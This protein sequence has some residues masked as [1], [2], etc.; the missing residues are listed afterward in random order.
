MTEL[1][2][3]LAIR[4]NRPVGS[5]VVTLQ[6]GMC[7]L[8]GGSFDPAYTLTI[9]SLPSQLKPEMNRRNTAVLQGHLRQ[10]LRVTQGRGYIRYLALT[11]DCMGNGGDTMA[12]RLS[13]EG[14]GELRK[15]RVRNASWVV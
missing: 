14:V 9:T 10:A 15:A 1:S 4:Y 6:H 7:L 13:I 8:F 12:E 2:Q 3:H 11:D 5:I